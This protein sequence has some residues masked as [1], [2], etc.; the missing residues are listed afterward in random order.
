[1]QKIR[2]ELTDVKKR[3]LVALAALDACKAENAE[4]NAE[5]VALKAI[6]EHAPPAGMR[7]SVRRPEVLIDSS[8]QP[9]RR[10]LSGARASVG[11]A[12]GKMAS[13]ST[14]KR[15]AAV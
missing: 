3:H 12:K 13:V 7:K 8:N 2:Q 14:L 1:V 6:D 9:L 5:L 15:L 10:S 4:L 11:A